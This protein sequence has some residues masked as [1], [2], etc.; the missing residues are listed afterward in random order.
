MLEVVP[1]L[2]KAPDGYSVL[3]IA[4]MCGAL[5]AEVS[6]VDLSKSLSN[7]V[8]ADIQKALHDYQVIFFRDQDIT[9]DQQKDFGRL[10]GSLNV[11]PV[12]EPLP[13]HP[14]ILQVVKEADA[15]NN[16]G[17]TWH[18]DATFLECPPM[19]SI[20]YAKEIPPF[21]G[22]TLFANLQ[23]AYEMLSDGMRRMLNGM[24]AVHSDAFLTQVNSERNATRSTKL[25]DGALETKE[26]LHPVIRTHPETGRKCLFINEPFTARFEG[27]TEKESRP[28]L[29]YLL[30]HIKSPEF[31]CRFRWQKGSLAFWDNRCTHHY[32][33]NDY[34]GH[35]REM[36][37]VTVNGD[38]PH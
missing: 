24:Q 8:F 17:D 22:D 38:R 21:G 18:S 11:H 9:P 3:D 5:G 13:G 36:H 34:H 2:A 29:D 35:R 7:E 4:P 1:T 27:M 12:Y 33:L 19:G 23:L 6:G 32:A 37:R 28:L 14:E 30:A 31:T 20:L 25:R 15:L 10:F 26:V 16:I